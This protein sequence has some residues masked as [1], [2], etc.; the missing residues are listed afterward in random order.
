VYLSQWQT[1]AS[2]GYTYGRHRSYPINL[3]ENRQSYKSDTRPQQHREEQQDPDFHVLR[4]L[5]TLSIKRELFPC[6][7][8]RCLFKARVQLQHASFETL[9]A[10]ST[11]IWWNGRVGTGLTLGISSNWGS[12]PFPLGT[13]AFRS[14]F[15]GH[16]LRE[17]WSSPSPACSPSGHLGA[18]QRC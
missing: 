16:S 6:V 8:F 9:L 11:G 1:C 15:I 10:L 3:L 2:R 13:A 7:T 18:M 5:S 12:D 17:L 14:V 4:C